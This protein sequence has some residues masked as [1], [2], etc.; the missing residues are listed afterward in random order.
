VPIHGNPSSQ[1]DFEKT[2]GPVAA[3]ARPAGGGEGG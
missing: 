1:A 3:R 2:V